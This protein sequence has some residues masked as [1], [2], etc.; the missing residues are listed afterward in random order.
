MISK[1]FHPDQM[2]GKGPGLTKAYLFLFFG[3]CFFKADAQVNGWQNMDLEKDGFFGISTEKAYEQLLS[4]KK[5]VSVVVAVIDSGVD[6]AHEDLKG[7]IWTRQQDNTHGRS[8]V[9]RDYGKEDITNLA[10]QNKSFYDSL[11]YTF[12]PEVYRVGYRHFRTMTNEY[13]SHVK[14]LQ[15]FINQLKEARDTLN[16]IVANMRNNEPSLEDFNRYQPLNEDEKGMIKLILSRLIFYPDF[17]T[18]RA[19]ELDSLINRA[20]YHLQ[21]GLSMTANIVSAGHKEINEGSLNVSNDPLGLIENP[22]ITPNHGTHVAGIIGA[23]RHNGKGIDGVA[24]NV[25]IMI[26]KVVSN[27]RELRDEDLASAIRFAVDNGAKVI[28]MSFG[29]SYTYDKT[30]VDDAVR[31]AMSKDVLIIHGA[32]N[33]G[34]DLDSASTSF[35]PTRNYLAGSMAKAW[36]T[37]GASG[38]KDDST[39]CAP[40]SNY[41]KESVDVFAPGVQIYSTVPHSEY[42]TWSGTSMA[43]PMVA[44]LAAL[45]R[46][47]YPRLTAVE[48]KDIILRSVIKRVT[49]TNKCGTGGVVNAYNAV[50][51]AETY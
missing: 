25:Q 16:A 48:V 15:I 33:E 41:G 44:G 42:D 31:Y 26:L 43:A 17:K 2:K 12:V 49:L 36:I 8:Y 47:Y 18:F 29:K 10:S 19:Y 30:A 28:N 37:V 1:Q 34:V 20:E 4:G 35:Y 11:T 3:L 24:D 50:K 27:I 45:I 23:Q 9:D 46:E 40:F 5:S 14:T 22:N 7:V 38:F 6:T 21:H 39:I 32:G 13:E 51:L